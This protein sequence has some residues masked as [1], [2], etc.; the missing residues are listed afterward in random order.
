MKRKNRKLTVASKQ[1]AV[2]KLAAKADQQR[3]SVLMMEVMVGQANLIG[4]MLTTLNDLGGSASARIDARVWAEFYQA[5]YWR[6]LRKA[7]R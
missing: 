2:K 6:L 7:R 1:R 4:R 5:K 3:A